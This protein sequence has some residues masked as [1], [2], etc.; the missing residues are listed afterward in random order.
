MAAEIQL[1]RPFCPGFGNPAFRQ[2][3]AMKPACSTRR[4]QCVPQ[5][6]GWLVWAEVDVQAGDRER[7]ALSRQPPILITLLKSCVQPQ[8][9]GTCRSKKGQNC[10]I[11]ANLLEREAAAIF[12]DRARS[13][14]HP[15]RHQAAP[16]SQA[17]RCIAAQRQQ[18]GPRCSPNT[19]TRREAHRGSLAVPAQPPE[20][21]LQMPGQAL[22][23]RRS[24]RSALRFA[25][26]FRQWVREA[27]EGDW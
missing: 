8:A 26:S 3:V 11:L 16:R 22:K 24:G 12:R 1:I 20:H 18:R 10:G 14:S 23:R 13:R 25:G 5:R 27:F 7:P 9:C 17:H 15:R 4:S 21:S 2:F 19:C 6:T